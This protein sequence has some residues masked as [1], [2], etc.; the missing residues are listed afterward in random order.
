MRMGLLVGLLAA[1]V[2]FLV[3]C[4]FVDLSD[5]LGFLPDLCLSDILDFR[6]H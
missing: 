1:V 6:W 4:V 2:A 5:I 3:L